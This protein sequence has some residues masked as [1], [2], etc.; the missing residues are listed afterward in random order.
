MVWLIVIS[1]WTWM[2]PRPSVGRS[3]LYLQ[4]LEPPHRKETLCLAQ[5]KLLQ[6]QPLQENCH[7]IYVMVIFK[8]SKY[9]WTRYRY[10]YGGH[11]SLVTFGC[12]GGLLMIYV[13]SWQ[14]EV[15][16]ILNDFLLILQ[17]P[18]HLQRPPT[19]RICWSSGRNVSGH[20]CTT[21][22][23]RGLLKVSTVTTNLNYEIVLQL[24][25]EKWKSD[26]TW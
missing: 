21:S 1:L 19:P 10:Q 22:E 2:L 17:W 26:V 14:V 4:P 18:I 23:I 15:S 5:G 3:P 9:L 12:Y 16:L 24:F 20:Q 7:V 6:P 25:R 11:K 13:G 8:G